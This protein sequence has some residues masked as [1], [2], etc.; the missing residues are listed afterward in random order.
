MEH[1]IEMAY[2]GQYINKS[3]RVKLAKLTKEQIQTS[4]LLNWD[5]FRNPKLGLTSNT[6]KSR[7]TIVA[8]TL[9]SASRYVLIATP[10]LFALIFAAIFYFS[11]YPGLVI[12]P[13]TIF[14]FFYFVFNAFYFLEAVRQSLNVQK[15]YKEMTE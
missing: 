6:Q 13:G 3:I 8:T 5:R 9:F 1:D 14:V 10:I 12:S 2:I 7:M 11:F 15:A 4:V